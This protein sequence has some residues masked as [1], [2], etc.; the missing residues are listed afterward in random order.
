MH[1][2]LLALLT[3]ICLL[4]AAVQAE[5][6][7]YVDPQGRVHIV[8]RPHPAA[9]GAGRPGPSAAA[10]AAV[11]SPDAVPGLIAW[12]RSDALQT[13]RT[14]ALES[15][16]DA[17]QF[18][19]TA[20]QSEAGRQPAIV[21]DGLNGRPVLRFDGVDDYL[22]ADSIAGA[23]QSAAGLT[24]VHVARAQADRAEYVWS[25]HG[26]DRFFDIARAGFAPGAG[27]AS[28]ARRRRGWIPTLI[29]R[30]G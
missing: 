28:K 4:P 19:H 29:R 5:V 13:I 30:R 12:F 1:P 26:G 27:C 18:V 3:L 7:R 17:S 16:L 15:W 23:L 25:L 8:D 9:S 10:S 22:R 2:R 6:S 24:V 14:P 21:P 20:G 11:P